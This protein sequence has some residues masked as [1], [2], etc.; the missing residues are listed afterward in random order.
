MSE[1]NEQTIEQVKQLV[2][3]LEVDVGE[4]SI[5][6]LAKE[7]QEVSEKVAEILEGSGF[8]MQIGHQI[9]INPTN[10]KIAEKLKGSSS[11]SEL[12]VPNS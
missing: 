3:Q 10:E 9:Q 12:E 7:K 8:S 4:E 6:E 11:D 1:P 2:N 5:K